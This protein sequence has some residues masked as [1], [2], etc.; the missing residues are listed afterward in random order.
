VKSEVDVGT[1]EEEFR[2]AF[3]E[4][5]IRTASVGVAKVGPI[6]T[7]NIGF[8]PRTLRQEFYRNIRIEEMQYRVDDLV[9]R[10][11]EVSSNLAALERGV[12]RIAVNLVPDYCTVERI[13][14]AVKA[15]CSIMSEWKK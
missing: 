13:K 2:L 8:D 14:K 3:V 11:A 5:D 6:L 4:D 9:H 15:I 7:I 1:L 12:I 10:S